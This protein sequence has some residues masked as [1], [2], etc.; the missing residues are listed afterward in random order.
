MCISVGPTT[1]RDSRIRCGLVRYV[2]SQ[3]RESQSFCL[4][5]AKSS[6][7]VENDRLKVM[8][9]EPQDEKADATFTPLL[10]EEEFWFCWEKML[11]NQ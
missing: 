11:K 3:K 4:S 1:S 7:K 9:N 6:S 8:K 5:L 2:Y 10:I